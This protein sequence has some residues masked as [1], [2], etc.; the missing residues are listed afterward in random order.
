MA[1]WPVGER[2]RKSETGF[3]STSTIYRCED[4][5]GCFFRTKCNKSKGNKR[6]V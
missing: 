2:R 6:L 5:A 3:V 4:C 1:L